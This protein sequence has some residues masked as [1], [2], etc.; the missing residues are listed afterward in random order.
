MYPLALEHEYVQAFVSEFDKYTSA[1][2]KSIKGSSEIHISSDLDNFHR[3]YKPD[4]KFRGRIERHFNLLKSW[5]ISKT[6]ASISKKLE[7]RFG[8]TL[9][10]VAMIETRKTKHDAE[11]KPMFPTI[12]ISAQRTEEIRNMV[13]EYVDTNVLLGNNARD[14]FFNNAQKEI[15]QGLRTGKSYNTIVDDLEKLGGGITRSKAEFWARDQTGKFFGT[16]TRMD[17]TSSGIPGYIWRITGYHTRDQHSKLSN[18]YHSWDKRPKML[19]GTKT[20]QAHPGE[21]YNCRCWAEPSLG[22]EEDQ[23]NTKPWKDEWVATA[24]E[25]SLSGNDVIIDSGIAK[26]LRVQVMQATKSVHETLDIT[27]IT[28]KQKFRFKNM[29]PSTPNYENID[30]Y[31]DP[32][33]GMIYIKKAG[34]KVT[35]RDLVTI[36]EI[37]HKLDK[38]YLSDSR[39]RGIE[40]S[41]AIELL[42]AI[43]QTESF[44]ILNQTR[45]N[46]PATMEGIY[47]LRKDSEWIAR[48]FEQFIALKTNNSKLMGKIE[49]R[50]LSYMKIYKVN[51]YLNQNEL[52]KIIPLFENYLR[53]K[54]RLK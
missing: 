3:N 53:K 18:T 34:P 5:S 47:E 25:Q 52:D 42:Q 41:E 51:S 38:E 11:D 12:S 16:L 23:Q 6:N 14:E 31:Y 10:K 44:K 54:G 50:R 40:T 36:H 24:S 22:D 1:F 26:P 45:S 15:F 21:D 32:D 9:S 30:G 20:I 33:T 13:N 17:Q 8:A 43:K 4:P 27:A 29:P 37:Y 46:N 28:D 39:V 7:K 19:Y 2:F 49:K 35:N 48:I